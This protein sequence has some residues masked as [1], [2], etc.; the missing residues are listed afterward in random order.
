MDHDG[1]INAIDLSLSEAGDIIDLLIY[2]HQEAEPPERL[3]LTS[4]ILTLL[5]AADARLKQIEQRLHPM[6]A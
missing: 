4:A 6:A 2:I 1:N 5:H 3:R